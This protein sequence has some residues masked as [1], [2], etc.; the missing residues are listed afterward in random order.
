MAP[1]GYPAKCNMR[2]N[3][4]ILCWAVLIAM[5]MN[6]VA[7][8]ATPGPLAKLWTG[9]TWF[10]T[11]PEQVGF[12]GMH[13]ISMFW[14]DVPGDPHYKAYYIGSPRYGTNLAKSYDGVNFTD[15]GQVVANGGSGS[16]DE[17]IAAFA[18]VVKD[19]GTYYLAYEGAGYDSSYPG[20]IGLAT[21]VDGVNF[22]KHGMILQHRSYGFE[23]GNIGTPSLHK[24]GS[25]WYLYY[26]GFDYGDCQIGLAT[27]AD[28]TNVTRVQSTPII[29][30]GSW[31]DWDSGTT[32]KRS[33]LIKEGD[34][35]YMAFE[36]SID[37]PYDT[38]RW[39]TGIA[40]STDLVHWDKLPSNPVLPQTQG[41]FGNDG[42]EMLYV[43]NDLYIYY[44]GAGNTTYRVKLVPEP[45]SLMLLGSGLG[46]FLHAYLWRKRSSSP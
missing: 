40:R 36:G 32:G 42:P 44:R 1:L 39:S 20:D 16:W 13:F 23:R 2:S 14:D 31:G 37:Q 22:T 28:P 35:W 5:T 11:E 3:T 4:L 38:A 8:A 27:G 24:E 46:L 26:H 7:Y 30:T 21:S 25:T 10:E 6:V 45:G 43:D 33:R 41:G 29:P 34:Y 19:G 17:R 18:G 9:E 12:A 15:L